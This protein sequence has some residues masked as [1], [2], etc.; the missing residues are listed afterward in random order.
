[1]NSYRTLLGTLGLVFLAA[2]NARG[3]D[4]R[5]NEIVTVLAKDAIPAILSPSFVEGREASRLE[6]ATVVGVEFNGDSRAY[7]VAILSR[8]EIVN[9]NVGG[10]PIAVTW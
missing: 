8:V 6:A 3:A 2:N 1:V 5:P 10:V 7:P 9:D 4:L